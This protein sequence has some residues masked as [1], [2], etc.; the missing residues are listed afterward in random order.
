[1]LTE[2]CQECKNWFDRDQPKY[3]GT[4]S[5]QNGNI[6]YDG[7]DMGA[8]LK[9]GQYFRIIGSTFNDGVWKYPEDTL[10]DEQ[11]DGSIWALAIPRD[12]IALSD[13]ID[14][15]VEKYGATDS[16]AMSP[17]YS[18]SFGGY[19]YSKAAGSV[20]AGESGTT[21]TWEGAF[22]RELKRYRKLL[23]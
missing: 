12:F 4:F 6:M 3:Y 2:L 9:S 18:E 14:E 17:Y 19:S 21:A 23:L 13:K 20:S 8:L 11:F 10:T 1:M 22:A 5:I 16:A 7:V 15:W